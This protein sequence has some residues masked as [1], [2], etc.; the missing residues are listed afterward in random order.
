MCYTKNYTQT[1]SNDNKLLGY[2]NIGEMSNSL[3]LGI[4]DV[5]NQMWMS[6]NDWNASN[7]DMFIN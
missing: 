4:L 5:L 7:L 3:C 1:G 6:Y 2:I